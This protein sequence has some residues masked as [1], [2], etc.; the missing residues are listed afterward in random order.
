MKI[1]IIDDEVNTAGTLVGVVDIMKQQG[2]NNIFVACT[3]G[4]LSGPAIER[5]AVAPITEFIL[6]DS[7]A[8]SPE[9]E[10]PLFKTISVIP[11]FAKALQDW[12]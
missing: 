3:H 10:L 7:I 8:R 1:L 6:T 2:A 11:L 12:Q 9:Q 4:V 5:L